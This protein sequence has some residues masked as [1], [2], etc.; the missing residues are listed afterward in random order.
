MFYKVNYIGSV[1]DGKV[2][3]VV[4]LINGV[5]N[6]FIVF[7]VNVIGCYDSYYS[8]NWEFFWNI[9]KEVVV[10]KVRGVVIYI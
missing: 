6:L 5:M 7:S 10:D 3:I 8:F 9:Y 4:I 1:I 2:I